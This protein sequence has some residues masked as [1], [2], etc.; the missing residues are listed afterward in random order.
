MLLIDGQKPQDIVLPLD[1]PKTI[2]FELTENHRCYR[3]TANGLKSVEANII[4]PMKYTVIDPKKGQA[5]EVI[6]ASNGLVQREGNGHVSPSFYPPAYVMK[7]D[8]V[9]NRDKDKGLVYA[10]LN[11]V[12]CENNPRF[13]D[14]FE[15]DL[16]PIYRIKNFKKD[17]KKS[18]MFSRIG[19]ALSIITDRDKLNDEKI[20][21][22]YKASGF[23]DAVILIENKEFDV[24]R[25]VL[26]ELA[27]KD[28]EK[29]FAIYEDG[30]AD[31]RS[32][33]QDALTKKVI[34]FTPKGFVWG[35]GITKNVP[36]IFASPK[37]LEQTQAVEKLINF[38]RLKD[39]S[40][41]YDEIKK[42]LG[43]K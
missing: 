16:R 34:A 31:V 30:L 4:L 8:I 5:E 41:V 29:F 1:L 35:E 13:K 40:G 12:F 17:N 10:L 3:R 39:D 9:L 38:L 33:I 20:A 21:K 6:F 32:T 14:G 42:E 23:S 43:K 36:L 28:P 11:S 18:Q 19:V 15:G 26:S 27:S 22:L 37:G 2:V 24:M 25:D 7:G